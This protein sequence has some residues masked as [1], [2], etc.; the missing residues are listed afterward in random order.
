MF[1]VDWRKHIQDYHLLKTASIAAGDKACPLLPKILEDVTKL[2][3]AEGQERYG[4][5]KVKLNVPNEEFFK[6]WYLKEMVPAQHLRHGLKPGTLFDIYTHDELHELVK[7]YEEPIYTKLKYDPTKARLEKT[8]FLEMS[9]ED[10]LR[11][12][13]EEAMAI[14]ME[15][16]LVPQLLAAAAATA[17]AQS[18]KEIKTCEQQDILQ[19]PPLPDVQEAYT[20]GLSMVLTTLSK[21]WFRSFGLEHWREL[22]DCDRDL[23]QILVD[24]GRLVMP[25]LTKTALGSTAPVESPRTSTEIRHSSVHHCGMDG[26]DVNGIAGADSEIVDRGRDDSSAQ[27]QV[28]EDEKDKPAAPRVSPPAAVP[29]APTALATSAAPVPAPCA[30]ATMES[31]DSSKLKALMVQIQE[32]KA[33]GYRDHRF[34]TADEVYRST[35][36]KVNIPAAAIMVLDSKT[37]GHSEDDGEDIT[38]TASATGMGGGGF[39]LGEGVIAGA[40]ILADPS[41][42]LLCE[43]GNQQHLVELV[44]QIQSSSTARP[45]LVKWLISEHRLASTAPVVGSIR[46]CHIL[47]VGVRS[48]T[49]YEKRKS[50]ESFTR[51]MLSGDESSEADACGNGDDDEEEEKGEGDKE[52]DGGEK[53]E[54]EVVVLNVELM[55][56]TSIK[57]DA[58]LTHTVMQVK[59]RLEKA[60]GQQASQMDLHS[61]SI[62]NEELA[63]RPLSSRCSLAQVLQKAMP[64]L[65]PSPS[66]PIPPPKPAPTAVSTAAGSTIIGGGDGSGDRSDDPAAKREFSLTMVIGQRAWTPLEHGATLEDFK[67]VLADA[68][69]TA[70]LREEEDRVQRDE[71]RRIKG[72]EPAAIAA[73]AAAAAACM[74]CESVHEVLQPLF[75][76]NAWDLWREMNHIPTFVNLKVAAATPTALATGAAPVPAPCATATLA[77]ANSVIASATTEGRGAAAPGSFV[78]PVAPAPFLFGTPAISTFGSL[79]PVPA[80]SMWKDKFGVPVPAVSTF[81]A[82]TTPPAPAPHFASTFSPASALVSSQRRIVKLKANP[83]GSRD[84]P[85]GGQDIRRKLELE[86]MGEYEL[87]KGVLKNGKGVWR[88]DPA[89]AI[90]RGKGLI[91]SYDS[92]A[93]VKG[94]PG[95]YAYQKNKNKSLPFLYWEDDQWCVGEDYREGRSQRLWMKVT[96]GAITPDAIDQRATWIVWSVDSPSQT[97]AQNDEVSGEGRQEPERAAGL[98]AEANRTCVISCH[99]VP[100]RREHPLMVRIGGAGQRSNTLLNRRDGWGGGGGGGKGAL[101]IMPPWHGH[102]ADGPDHPAEYNTAV[103]PTRGTRTWVVYVK[104]RQPEQC[105]TN[106]LARAETVLAPVMCLIAASGE[107]STP[108]LKDPTLLKHIERVKMQ[109]LQA[110]KAVAFLNCVTPTSDSSSLYDYGTKKARWTIR[111]PNS[112]KEVELSVYEHSF[113]DSCSEGGD[114]SDDE[115]FNTVTTEKHLFDMTVTVKGGNTY[116]M[117]HAYTYMVRDSWDTQESE[118]IHSASFSAIPVLQQMFATAD[119]PLE[120]DPAQIVDLLFHTVGTA[121]GSPSPPDDEYGHGWDQAS[122]DHTRAS[123]EN[124]GGNLHLRN[125]QAWHEALISSEKEEEGEWTFEDECMGVRRRLDQR[126][127]VALQD[128]LER[129]Q[130]NVKAACSKARAVSENEAHDGIEQLK[131]LEAQAQNTLTNFEQRWNEV[132]GTGWLGL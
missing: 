75:S 124:L 11:L 33:D 21:G 96:S 108:V 70:T 73:A 60:S 49:A 1:P 42:R 106:M 79:T 53:S 95:S 65:P 74:A 63:G 117:M 8:L 82:A 5:S 9:H 18:H 76:L 121:K 24:D 32:L 25:V 43:V 46:A 87:V 114:Y 66:P 50:W 93:R 23:H 110:K 99:Q 28:Q 4:A 44:K 34:S 105:T 90:S 80:A 29:T 35:A 112:E 129:A 127:R 119:P 51:K 131:V 91:A 54:G 72:G 36:K 13:R 68:C 48:T 45:E 37:T 12:V 22:R 61:H 77:A 26:G 126:Q 88:R 78:S 10:Q 67:R 84:V 47:G 71:R 56:G 15:R 52:E 69:A 58:R 31:I 3:Q 16:V 104:C 109:R 130:H 17:E 111:P 98:R 113:H 128:E 94:L 115:G 123:D 122:G 101:V 103:V 81:G 116:A 89:A 64:L 125:S 14:G 7:Y 38:R 132:V 57:M 62:E 118:Q 97:A 83:K 39:S 6:V 85:R 19:P 55:N 107:G 92:F 2:R 59:R 40:R 41:Q 100:E 20:V 120:L 30:T 102:T 86:T 27:D